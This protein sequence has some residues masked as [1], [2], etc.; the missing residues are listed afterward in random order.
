MWTPSASVSAI[1]ISRHFAGCSGAKPDFRRASIS[2]VFPA[3]IRAARRNDG[4]SGPPGGGGGGVVEGGEGDGRMT[5]VR[6]SPIDGD[7]ATVGRGAAS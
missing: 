1:A 5:L 7:I 3:A 6:F 2:A 4:A